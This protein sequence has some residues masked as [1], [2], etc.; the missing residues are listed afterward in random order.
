MKKIAATTPFSEQ[1]RYVGGNMR[2][3]DTAAALPRCMAVTEIK[4]A[5]PCWQDSFVANQEMH[6]TASSCLWLFFLESIVL[7]NCFTID[8]LIVGL[9]CQAELHQFS[10]CLLL[11]E[12]GREERLLLYETT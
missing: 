3:C 9:H 5:H 1:R 8:A 7:G 2:V 6:K 4:T 11:W 10:L 12:T